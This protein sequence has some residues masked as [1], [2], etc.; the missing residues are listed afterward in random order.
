[1]RGLT[2]CHSFDELDVAA[3]WSSSA[4]VGGVAL[5]EVEAGL[6][7]AKVRHQEEGSRHGVRTGN[8]GRS[9]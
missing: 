8:Q 6:T 5:G 1:M 9:S 3:L 2:N 7:H 4:Q